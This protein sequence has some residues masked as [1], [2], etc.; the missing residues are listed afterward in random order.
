VK[1]TRLVQSLRSAFGRPGPASVAGLIAL[2]LSCV[3]VYLLLGLAARDAAT[4]LPS[5][6]AGVSPLSQAEATVTETR[7]PTSTATPSGP[8]GTSTSTPTYTPISY[9]PSPAFLVYTVQP[10]DTLSGIARRYNTTVAEMM[11]LNSLKSD[12]LSVGQEL[13][14]PGQRHLS[15]AE[16]TWTPT[17]ASVEQTPTPTATATATSTSIP[18]SSPATATRQPTA[19]PP[20][21]ARS[22]ERPVVAFY[23]AWYGLDQ[24]QAG[25]VPDIPVVKYTSKD[26]STMVRHVQQARSAGIDAFAVAWYGPTVHNNQTET[27]FQTMLGVAAEQGF[28]CTV[29]FETRSPFYSSQADIVNALRYL[30]NN[31]AAHP[32]FFRF[33]G[34]PLIFFWAVKDV[35]TGQGQSAVDAWASIRQQ[36]DPQHNTLWI[37]DG[38]DTEFL[39]VFDGHHLY[40]ITWNPPANVRNTLSTWGDRVRGYGTEHGTRKLWVATVMP[41]YNDLFA[42]DRSGRF[43]HDRRGGAYYRETWEA[44]MDSAP[45][46]IVI[47]S[48]NEWL[49]GTQIEP[50]ISYGNLYLDLTSELSAAF[51]SGR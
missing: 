38:A 48:F 13:L 30:I 9:I 35:F 46:L 43:A 32:A 37:A 28:H 2:V 50:S 16:A 25:K 21:A 10:G 34:K 40:N 15:S 51:K 5:E 47:T 14:I 19:A 1:P 49:E 11:E 8:T 6:E 39:R 33:E 31:H 18:V 42:Q 22:G 4:L 20:G 27:N 29:D 36:V 7:T 24:W 26:R 3:Y 17:D 44:A 12:L 45:D 23:Y 41:G